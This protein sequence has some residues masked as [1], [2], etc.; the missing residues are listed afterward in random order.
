M[1]NLRTQPN[2]GDEPGFR[3]ELVE[4]VLE[5]LSSLIDHTRLEILKKI[6]DVDDLVDIVARQVCR[7]IDENSAIEK[8]DVLS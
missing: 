1:S 5:P 2:K 7:E 3:R 4:L 6:Q 8:E